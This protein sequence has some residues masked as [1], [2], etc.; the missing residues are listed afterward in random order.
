MWFL[1]DFHMKKIKYLKWMIFLPIALSLLFGCGGKGK[2]VKA[3]EG[4]S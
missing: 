3:I 1:E 2:D 4:R